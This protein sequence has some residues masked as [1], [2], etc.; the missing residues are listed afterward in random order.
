MPR[1]RDFGDGLI[2][3]VN[4]G[5]V[6]AQ[7]EQRINRAIPR[8]AVLIFHLMSSVRYEELHRCS[9]CW[10]ECRRWK[11][12]DQEII[13]ARNGRFGTDL[14]IMISTLMAPVGQA[15]KPPGHFLL[16]MR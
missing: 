10:S 4:R 12:E 1:V 8:I 16:R 11:M 5:G 3:K 15:A 2:W 13:M 7:A 6:A 14:H 9:L